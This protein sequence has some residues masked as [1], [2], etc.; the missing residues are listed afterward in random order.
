MN[1]TRIIPAI[2]IVILFTIGFAHGTYMSDL[3]NLT[4]KTEN[5]EEDTA[6]ERA[7]EAGECDFCNMEQK[8]KPVAQSEIP[9]QT[10]VPVSMP[11]P[12]PDIGIVA[13]IMVLLAIGIVK[14]K[15]D[16]I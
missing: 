3:I 16:K 11:K 2:C 9:V 13:T 1:K 8:I 10:P 4:D 15:D 6:L 12:S 7:I 5:I 14:I